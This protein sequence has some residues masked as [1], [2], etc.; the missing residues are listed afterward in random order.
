MTRN[1]AL[2]AAARRVRSLAERVPEQHR[3]DIVQ[4]WGELLDSLEGRTDFQA[5]AVIAEWTERME[6]RMSSAPAR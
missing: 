4:A 6:A 5:V 2:A 1:A 3:P